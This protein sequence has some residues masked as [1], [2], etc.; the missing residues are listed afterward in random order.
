[1]RMPDLAS[2]G[3]I[4]QV[5]ATAVAPTVADPGRYPVGPTSVLRR[6]V[7]I[8]RAAAVIGTAVA[9]SLQFNS[10]LKGRRS[11]TV[12]GATHQCR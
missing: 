1:M 4:G 10:A 6:A 5:G 12:A 8:G 9:S 7:P 3:A 2:N 11:W